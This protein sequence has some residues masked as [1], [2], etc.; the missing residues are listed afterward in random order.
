MEGDNGRW[1]NESSS[2]HLDFPWF[3]GRPTTTDP[4]ISVGKAVIVGNAEV[5]GIKVV[6]IIEFITVG[7]IEFVGESEGGLETL[8]IAWP[9]VGIDE[10]GIIAAPPVGIKVSTAD[11]MELR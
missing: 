6:I 4:L 11:G 8:T 9:L 10:G 1:A 2:T 3:S 7:W 5:V